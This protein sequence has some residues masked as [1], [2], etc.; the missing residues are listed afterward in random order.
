MAKILILNGSTRKDG[1]TAKLTREFTNG[2]KHNGN[3]VQ[4]IFTNEL[5]FSEPLWSNDQL[6]KNPYQLEDFLNLPGKQGKFYRAIN[7]AE[8]I[9]FASPIYWWSV[10]GSLKQAIDYLQPL[11]QTIGYR[12]FIKKSILLGVA[13]G[14]DYS[15][16]IDWYQ[17]FNIFI[18]LIW[19]WY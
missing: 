1:N 8:I 11:Q 7:E 5:V 18:G 10:A 12:N 14:K 9:V 4:E 15:L 16:L 2:A 6:T 13:G 17:R 19:G 3:Q